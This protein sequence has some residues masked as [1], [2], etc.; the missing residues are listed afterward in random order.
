MFRLS[1]V[2]MGFY[3]LFA[4]NEVAHSVFYGRRRSY[5]MLCQSL[6]FNTLF[7]MFALF[8]RR[9]SGADHPAKP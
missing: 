1:I 4:F 6:L 8:R 7:V 5:L 2:S 9:T 3:L